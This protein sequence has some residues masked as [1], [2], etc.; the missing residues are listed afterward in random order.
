MFPEAS[1]NIIF[2]CQSRLQ[3]TLFAVRKSPTPLVFLK[4][5]HSNLSWFIYKGAAVQLKY[6]IYISTTLY[7]L[8]H[9]PSGSLSRALVIISAEKRSISYLIIHTRTRTHTIRGVCIYSNLVD[10]KLIGYLAIE[11][12]MQRQYVVPDYY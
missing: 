5:I 9:M 2:S 10:K 7:V 1:G 3:N 4:E 8:T 6:L 11:M 12:C